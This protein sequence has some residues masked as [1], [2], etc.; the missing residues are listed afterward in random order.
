MTSEKEEHHDI[1][2]NV[3]AVWMGASSSVNLIII[4]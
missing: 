2:D 4:M 1:G 3:T